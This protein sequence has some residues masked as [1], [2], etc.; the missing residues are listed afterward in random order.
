MNDDQPMAGSYRTTSAPEPTRVQST[1]CPDVA[2]YN[3]ENRKSLRESLRHKM[4]SSTRES[5]EQLVESPY[6]I[7]DEGIVNP[8]LEQTR[9]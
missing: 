5:R 8:A 1:T 7:N 4:R 3:T 9:L 6:Y 2:F